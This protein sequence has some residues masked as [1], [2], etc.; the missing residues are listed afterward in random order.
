MRRRSRTVV[1]KGRK[2]DGLGVIVLRKTQV[3]FIDKSKW[4]SKS[5]ASFK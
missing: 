4:T 3:A 1:M 2:E 5:C